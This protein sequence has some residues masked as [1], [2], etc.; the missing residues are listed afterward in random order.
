MNDE[1]SFLDDLQD[2]MC[3]KSL[4]QRHNQNQPNIRQAAGDSI[5]FNPLTYCL[6]QIILI[7]MRLQMRQTPSF[8]H[9]VGMSIQHCSMK[10]AHNCSTKCIQYTMYIS[11]NTVQEERKQDRFEQVHEKLWSRNKGN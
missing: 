6:L 7:F 11:T 10:H 1:R 3:K 4:F 5:G 9:N 2:V 8:I